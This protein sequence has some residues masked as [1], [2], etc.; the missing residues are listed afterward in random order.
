[1]YVQNELKLQAQPFTSDR[2]DGNNLETKR[3]HES[4]VC[5]LLKTLIKSLYNEMR[6]SIVTALNLLLKDDLG[7]VHTETFSTNASACTYRNFHREAG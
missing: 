6:L 5:A 1:M 2:Y 7:N 3:E 4:I